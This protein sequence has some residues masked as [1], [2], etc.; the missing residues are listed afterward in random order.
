M[1]LIVGLGNVGQPY[2]GTRHNVGFEVVR[3]LARTRR[4]QW[5]PKFKAR[6]TIALSGDWKPGH[7]V[8]RL[9]LPQLMMNQ[10]GEALATAA[11]RPVLPQDMLIVCDDVNLPLGTLRLRPK[12]SDGGHHGLASCLEVLGTH[13][14]ARLRIGVGA[15]PLPR[16]LTEFVLSPFDAQERPTVHQM[17]EQAAVACELWA[18][19][20]IEVAMNRVNPAKWRDHG[21]GVNA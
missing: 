11:E 12:G 9:F 17:I 13:A 6:E 19:Q 8:V 1:K 7:A 18:T 4:V 10:S 20:G 15:M 16:D 14:V 21:G 2:E 5:K 3:R